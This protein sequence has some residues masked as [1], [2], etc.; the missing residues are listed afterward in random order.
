MRPVK[1]DV[2][3]LTHDLKSIPDYARKVEALGYDCLWSAETQHDP[4]LPL[5]VAATVTSKIQARHLDRRRLPAQPDD[6]RPYFLGPREGL[7]RAVHPRAGLAGE[8]PQRAPLL[9]EVRVARAEDARGGPGHARD[10]G[11]LAETEPRWPSRASSS[12][13]TS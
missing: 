2:G 6:S 3:M 8:G 12:A 9:G 7:G 11:L 4:F 10:L 1:L 13:S 5:A